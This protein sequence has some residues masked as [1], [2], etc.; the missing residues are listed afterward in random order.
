MGLASI[1]L[2]SGTPPPF[3]T[4]ALVV[5]CG[6]IYGFYTFEIVL[7][8]TARLL[9]GKGS[10]RRQTYL[11]SLFYVPL[12][13]VQ[14]VLATSPIGGH[15]LFGLVA[16]YSL[17]PTTTSLKA[18]HGFSTARAVMTWIIPI[19]LNIVVSLAVVLLVSRMRS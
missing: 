3:S 4:W 18:A 8:I 16:A 17:I 5:P 10:F 9:R 6:V 11:Q 14:Q 12:A 13:I 19:L 7:F 2:E 15:L 1:W